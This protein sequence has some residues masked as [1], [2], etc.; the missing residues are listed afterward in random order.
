M[1]VKSSLGTYKLVH[2]L[3]AFEVSK[4]PIHQKYDT[5]TIYFFPSKKSDN[6]HGHIYNYLINFSYHVTY[7]V[8]KS[9]FSKNKANLD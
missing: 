7:N 6:I 9:N 4:Q 2:L 8:E 1:H 5:I 3:P